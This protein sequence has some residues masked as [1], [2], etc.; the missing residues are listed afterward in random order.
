[1]ET[2]TIILKS[3]ESCGVRL[4]KSEN[5][6]K[7]KIIYVIKKLLDSEY[8]F[9]KYF[10]NFDLKNNTNKQYKNTFFKS[11]LEESN[12]KSIISYFKDNS[13]EIFK[14]SEINE[15]TYCQ[16]EN[17]NFI[18][19]KKEIYDL[20]NTYSL[21]SF[22]KKEKNTINNDNKGKIINLLGVYEHLKAI[23]HFN[24]IYYHKPKLKIINFDNGINGYEINKEIIVFI[25]KKYEEKKISKIYKYI[26]N[27]EKYKIIFEISSLN[28]IISLQPINNKAENLIYICPVKLIFD[29]NKKEFGKNG[30]LTFSQNLNYKLYKTKDLKINNIYPITYVRNDSLYKTNYFFATLNNKGKQLI[31]LYR[32]INENQM[33]IDH[34]SDIP[35]YIKEKIIYIKQFRKTGR[36][37]ISCPNKKYYY[38]SSP[39][40]STKMIFE[41]S[42]ELE[43]KLEELNFTESESGGKNAIF[44]DCY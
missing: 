16:R 44:G 8:H 22:M 29:Y 5:L 27:N 28:S 11:K 12:S 14:D 34:I 19:E 1:M 10:S 36:L 20:I 13:K 37:V 43:N 40:L 18:K 25:A 21:P 32:I 23:F 31:S 2:R 6:F 17:E 30:L 39:D 9:K 38:Y 7:D 26:I 35:L 41:E 15:D 4:R 33:I 24:F 42:V 3:I